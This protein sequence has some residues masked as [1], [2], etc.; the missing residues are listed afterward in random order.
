MSIVLIVSIVVVSSVILIDQLVFRRPKAELADTPGIH[1]PSEPVSGETSAV[2]NMAVT[3]QNL[4]GLWS[5]EGP[6]GDL[7]DP[8]TGYTTGSIYNGEWYLFRKD[9]TF[10]HVIVGSG[11]VISGGAVLEGKYAV[12]EGEILLT[13]IRESWYPNPAAKGQKDMYENR[14]ASDFEITYRYGDD[15]DTLIIDDISYFHR[16][17]DQK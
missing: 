3:D 4:I 16:V 10:R 5:T 7:V 13:D 9:G 14:S 2:E 12:R 1:M 15:D 6:S 11:L 8:A 17:N